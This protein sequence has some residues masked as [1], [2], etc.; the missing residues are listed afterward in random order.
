MS[1]CP[2]IYWTGARCTAPAGHAEPHSAPYFDE[3]GSVAFVEVW[4]D[5]TANTPVHPWLT[6]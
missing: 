3:D 6:G 2:A 5:V 4:E 1:D